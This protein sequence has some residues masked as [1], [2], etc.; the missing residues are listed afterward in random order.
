MAIARK[1]QKQK[2]KTAKQLAEEAA[3]EAGR[4]A[5]CL[6]FEKDQRTDI[7]YD[8]VTPP[9]KQVTMERSRGAT[10]IRMGDYVFVTSDLS[11]NKC[12]H[13]GNGY[14]VDFE[15]TGPNRTFTVQY[16]RCSISGMTTEPAITY[17]CITQ[18][19]NP[20]YEVT[21]TNRK[22]KACPPSDYSSTSESS[23][24][25]T[26][27]EPP[28]LEAVLT[29]GWQ[30]GRAKGWRAK[31]LGVYQENNRVKRSAEHDHL[32]QVDLMVLRTVLRLNGAGLTNS[33]ASDDGDDKFDRHRNSGG[34]YAKKYKKSKPISISYLN[35]AWG[36]GKNY[37]N[38]VLNQ[39]PPEPLRRKRLSLVFNQ[40]HTWHS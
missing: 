22:R 24:E 17:G 15:G 7:D 21:S 19:P 32:F 9:V 12:S 40:S 20:A 10:D 8:L 18:I 26:V 37:A 29:N 36:V 4:K 33:K 5:K 27:L 38:R 13:G 35:Y 31:D 16:D 30:R 11:P 3:L 23:S 2:E 25:S 14:V 28:K 1:A 34:T 39:K 6:Q